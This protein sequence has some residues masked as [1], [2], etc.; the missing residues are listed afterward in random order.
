MGS[1]PPGVLQ[2]H[3]EVKGLPTDESAE[4]F[5]ARVDLTQFLLHM[6][7]AMAKS[8]SHIC[9]PE[10]EGFPG[11]S[12]C[13]CWAQGPEPETTPTPTPR[14]CLTPVTPRLHI[15]IRADT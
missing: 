5:T 3:G 7:K 8:P 12:A 1:S 14:P 6:D 9:C 13:S 2:G 10:A 15:L 11:V 4:W